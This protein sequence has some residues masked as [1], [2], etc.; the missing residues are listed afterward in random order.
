MEKGFKLGIAV[1][2]LATIGVYAYYFCQLYAG[3]ACGESISGTC[4]LMVPSLTAALLKLMPI[5]PK[6]MFIPLAVPVGVGVYFERTNRLDKQLAF[7]ITTAIC[8]LAVFG[9][10]YVYTRNF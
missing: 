7:Y 1:A 8:Y 10:M 9:G 4:R 2:L 3:S 6:T 5:I